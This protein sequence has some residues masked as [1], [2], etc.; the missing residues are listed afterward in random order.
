[1]FILGETAKAVSQ[2]YL[3]IVNDRRSKLF[4]SLSIVK[5][6]TGFADLNQQGLPLGEVFTKTVVDVFSLHVPE[7]LILQPDLEIRDNKGR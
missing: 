1:M 7:A 4:A 5:G 3:A 2:Y 6:S